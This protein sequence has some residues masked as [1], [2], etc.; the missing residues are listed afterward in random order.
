MRAIARARFN[1]AV[2]DRAR[3]LG[4]Y[5]RSLGTPAERAKFARLEAAKLAVAM[6]GRAMRVSARLGDDA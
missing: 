4:E 2:A 3:A 1:A 5:E 6:R